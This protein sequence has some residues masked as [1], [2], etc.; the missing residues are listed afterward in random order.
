M[1]KI[2]LRLLILLKNKFLL[3]II[4]YSLFFLGSIFI[5]SGLGNFFSSSDEVIGLIFLIIGIII[6]TLLWKYEKIF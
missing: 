2:Y 3:K 1:D 6:I 4:Y 5:L